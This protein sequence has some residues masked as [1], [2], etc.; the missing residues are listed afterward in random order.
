MD[1][2]SGQS[3]SPTPPKALGTS[4]D[5]NLAEP[6]SPKS[7]QE[8]VTR[9]PWDPEKHKAQAAT[10]VAHLIVWTFAGTIA[11]VLITLALIIV[12]TSNPDT[13]KRFADTLV[14]VLESLGKFLTAVFAPL[15]AFVLGYYFSEKQR[16]K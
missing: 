6:G 9:E 2:P 5:L 14:S 4:I 12:V 13:T 10:W 15:L 11:L 8:Y 16:S 1:N 3:V 7:L